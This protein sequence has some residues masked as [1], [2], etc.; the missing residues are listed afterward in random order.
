MQYYSNDIE[1]TDAMKT[2]IS[3][4]IKKLDKYIDYTNN[5]RCS[6]K[7]EGNLFKLE[8]TLNEGISPTIRASKEG[9]D[10]YDLCGDVIDKLISQIKKYHSTKNYKTSNHNNFRDFEDTN[11]DE[12]DEVASKEK[13]IIL[14]EMTE[15]EAIEN[16]ELLNHNFFVY[17]DIDQQNNICIVYKRTNTK[18]KYGIIITR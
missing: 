16:M 7:K 6:L 4:N 2:F 14:N 17:K 11:K 8:I 5:S 9:I 3:D 15:K 13:L 18:E 10:F 12:D 1:F